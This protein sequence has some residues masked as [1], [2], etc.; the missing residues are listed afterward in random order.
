MPTGE[1]YSSIRAIRPIVQSGSLRDFLKG[2]EKL[3]ADW[4]FDDRKGYEVDPLVFAASNLHI[5]LFKRRA[6]TTARV[7]DAM[8]KMED[9]L[10]NE[11]HQTTRFR[12]SRAGVRP[13]RVIE[14]KENPLPRELQS[15]EDLYVPDKQQL[16]LR[17]SSIIV[18]SADESGHPGSELSLL[19]SDGPVVDAI[20]AQCGLINEAADRTNASKLLPRQ[21]IKVNP[22]ELPI[23]RAPFKS[24]AS[25]GEFIE[26]LSDGL[27]VYD[28]GL[29]SV[30]PRHEL[31]LPSQTPPPTR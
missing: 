5:T 31:P 26:A 7:N 23:M 16:L 19:L 20:N 21:P 9:Y 12:Q 22:L 4:D 30:T 17:A 24:E 29:K 3:V 18:S 13:S 8:R 6:L 25:R 2:A 11:Y 15:V 10:W 28:I 14:Q 1:Q 27:Q